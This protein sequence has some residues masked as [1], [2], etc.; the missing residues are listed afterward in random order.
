MREW[1][2]LFEK[3]YRGTQREPEQT[4][5]SALSFTDDKDVASVYAA[6]PKTGDYV[7]GSRVSAADF[8]MKNPVDLSSHMQIDLN[9]ALGYAGIND[10]SENVDDVLRLVIGLQRL[11]ERGMRFHY[12]IVNGLDWDELRFAI[13]KSASKEDWDTFFNLLDYTIVDSYAICDTPT[14]VRIAKEHGHDG[15]IHLDNFDAGV[16]VADK[17]LGKQKPNSHITYRPFGEIKWGL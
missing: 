7:P 1:L 4:V 16:K 3:Y 9:N 14:F 12:K 8:E 13:H 15:I 11:E 2:N 5:R 17:L 6:S 10:A